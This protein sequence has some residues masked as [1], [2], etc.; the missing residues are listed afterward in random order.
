M[1]VKIKKMF[2]CFE[3]IATVS[4]ITMGQRISTLMTTFFD[5]ALSV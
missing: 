3:P 2:M 4:I 1:I 5:N